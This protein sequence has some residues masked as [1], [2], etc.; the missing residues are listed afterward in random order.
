MGSWYAF[1]HLQV[2]TCATVVLTRSYINMTNEVVVSRR[3]ILLVS[4]CNYLTRLAYRPW[5]RM[6][7]FSLFSKPFLM[8]GMWY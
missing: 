5:K 4:L 8:H 2:D 1:Y 3:I 7:L 6:G